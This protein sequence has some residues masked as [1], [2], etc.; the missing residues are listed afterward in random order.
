MEAKWAQGGGPRFQWGALA[1][2]LGLGTW[3]FAALL[4]FCEYQF[5]TI[6][7]WMENVEDWLVEWRRRP[8]T[9]PQ[10]P[11]ADGAAQESFLRE[12]AGPPEGAPAAAPATNA[13]APS[14]ASEQRR[15]RP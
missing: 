1:Q 2:G 12:I 10:D 3:L 13:G 6:T 8:R 7:S 14:K 11:L 4:A 9:A 15:Q 5:G